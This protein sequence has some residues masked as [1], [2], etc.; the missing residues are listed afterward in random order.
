MIATAPDKEWS[1]DTT[2]ENPLRA[3]GGPAGRT[4]CGGA[5]GH[6]PPPG[7]GDP[8]QEAAVERGGA[9]ELYGHRSYRLFRLRP[10][11][12]LMGLELERKER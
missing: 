8:R 6:P 1:S 9:G 5:C 12:S 4:A 7:R 3:S 11:A 2:R 10:E